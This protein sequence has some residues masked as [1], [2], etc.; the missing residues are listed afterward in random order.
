LALKQGDAV[1]RNA[2]TKAAHIIYSSKWAADSAINYYGALPAKVSIVDFGAN[3]LGL[4]GKEEVANKRVSSQCRLLFLG[5]SWERKGGS[6][7]YKTFLELKRRNID[8]TLIII[9][10]NPDLI[11]ESGLT[12]IPFLD[13]NKRDDFSRLYTILLE[14]DFLIVPTRA[15]CTPI[16]FC[17]AAAFGVPVITTNTGGITS[18]IKEGVN[19][20]CL[21]L[22]AGEQEYSNLIEK[23]WL[24]KPAYNKLKKTCRKEFD[25][26]LNW[27]SWIEK[28]N[29]RLQEIQYRNQ[30]TRSK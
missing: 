9:G 3:L 14:T 19:G 8:C 28:F 13:K 15:D 21:P 22:E 16:V 2:I 11:T 7:A 18:V 29:G 23:L 27:D 6:I 25:T 30:T 26:R 24:N 4:P 12:I 20:L 5:V 10:C 1:E 17:E